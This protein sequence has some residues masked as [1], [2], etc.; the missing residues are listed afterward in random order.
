LA[1]STVPGVVYVPSIHT[2]TPHLASCSDHTLL[3]NLRSVVIASEPAAVQ[4]LVNSGTLRKH[5]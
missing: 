2:T 1:R 5:S 3:F 4:L